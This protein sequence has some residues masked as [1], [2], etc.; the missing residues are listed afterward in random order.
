MV[1]QLNRVSGGPRRV[2]ADG[3]EAETLVGQSDER[4]MAYSEDLSMDRRSF[5]GS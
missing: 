3:A 2:L 1:K 5:R 4:V